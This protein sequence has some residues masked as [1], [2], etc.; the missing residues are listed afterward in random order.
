MEAAK[1]AEIH[2]VIMRMPEQYDTIVG[3]R[4]GKLSGGQRQRIAIARALVR[5]PSVLILD[6]A[7]SALDPATESAINE[8][9]EAIARTKEKTIISVTH[10]LVSIQNSDQIFVFDQG[11]LVESGTHQSLLEIETGKYNES[12][13]KQNGFVVS[14]DGVHITVTNEK[15]KTIPSLQDIEE[16]LLTE[17]SSLF[18]TEV[19]AKNRDI[20]V[21]GDDKFYVIVRGTVDVLIGHEQTKVATLNDGDFFGEIALIK[22]I[23]R[24]ATIKSKSPVTLLSLQREA[25]QTLLKKAPHIL[26]VLE[27]RK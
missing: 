1:A 20:I 24:T 13:E 10:R 19:Y 9:I 15:L 14:E 21:E 3:D 12:W 18:V 2:E 8:T 11:R 25:F 27:N 26:A 23:P 4:G 16:D 5:N 17:L 6:E 22:N 7:T